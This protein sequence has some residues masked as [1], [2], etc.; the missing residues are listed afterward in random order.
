LESSDRASAGPVDKKLAKKEAELV[1]SRLKK[2]R[3][4]IESWDDFYR[5]KYSKVINN[6]I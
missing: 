5:K 1:N 2:W 6:N 3:A 4:M